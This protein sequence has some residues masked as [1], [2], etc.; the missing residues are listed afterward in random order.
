MTTDELWTKIDAKMSSMDA[1]L[2][3]VATTVRLHEQAL[4]NDK[5][6]IETVKEEASRQYDKM[7]TRVGKLEKWMWI[8]LGAGGAAGAGLAKLLG[9]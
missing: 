9:M 7:D 6:Q 2:D 4:A 5:K 8:S 3:E 1:K